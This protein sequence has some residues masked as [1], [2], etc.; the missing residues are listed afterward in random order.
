MSDNQSTS[1]ARRKLPLTLLVLLAGGLAVA[2][3]LTLRPAPRTVEPTEPPPP[4]VAVVYAEPDAQ[5]LSVDSQGTVEPRREIDLILQVAGTVQWVNEH[6]VEGGFFEEGETLLE[7]DPRDYELAL[8]RAEAR[9]AEAEQLLATERGR[10]RQAERE[11]RDLGNEEANALFLRKPQLA[12]AEAQVAAAK[13]DRDQARLDLER[14]RVRAPFSGRVRQAGVDRGQYVSPGTP[15][16]RIYDISVAQ[17]RLPLSD[18]QAALVDLPLGFRGDADN[19]GPAVLIS[20]TIAGE[21]YTWQGRIA[22]TD[23]SIDLNSR[24]YYAVAEVDNPFAPRPGATR[25]P[26]PVGL[27]VNARISGRELQDVVTVPRRALFK[28]DKVYTLDSENRVQ[29]QTVHVLQSDPD[30]AWIK[31]DL[32]SGEAIVVGGQSFLIP[33]MVVAP[34]PA[35]EFA[36]RPGPLQTTLALP[37]R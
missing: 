18:R 22:R 30:Q 32:V 5:A 21:R 26:L 12:A 35:A 7:V 34:Q 19:P 3:L 28:N 17:I 24:F 37:S 29:L 13:A 20:G 14:T 11:W 31:G 10:A 33:G 15:A 36:G 6:F 27:F 1:T 23:A 2:A 16:G 9:V 8:I 25:T 4:Q